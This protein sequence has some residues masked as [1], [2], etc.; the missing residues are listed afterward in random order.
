VTLIGLGVASLAVGYSRNSTL[1]RIAAVCFLAGHLLLGFAVWA[2]MPVGA[3]FAGFIV[4]D[5]LIWPV[6]AFFY[7]IFTY[8]SARI[9]RQASTTEQEIR[10]AAGQEERNRLAQD[11]HDSVKQQ[12]FS[13]QTDLATAEA[14][15]DDDTAGARAAIERARKTA[16]DAMSEMSALL[17]RL[18]RDPIESAGLVEA[19]RRQCEALGFQ[20]GAT[21]STAFGDLPVADIPTTA[22]T[23]VFRI[24]QESLAN[25]ARHA[26]A[27]HVALQLN[28]N[29]ERNSLFLEIRDD[30]RG[31]DTESAAAGMGLRNMRLR[32]QE[33]GA[34]L[35]IRSK[36]GEGTI[37]RLWLPLI[38]V[39]QER[40][41]HHIVRLLAVLIPAI[42]AA[43]LMRRWDTAAPFLFPFVV[44]GAAFAAFH[45]IALKR[46][47]S[48]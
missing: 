10:E 9:S 22:M 40:T 21:V 38:D 1:Q 18:R 37:T 41:K 32:A 39:K 23:P 17:D 29:V 13:V 48:T 11:L 46:V 8:E 33:I 15:W 28:T 31:F 45:L 30:G 35:D 24:A 16:R 2:L 44:V 20:T 27:K 34:E 7:G 43:G 25:I 42:V 6:P 4:F 3:T 19:L 47:Q 5:L 14:R 26:R 12:I 36:A